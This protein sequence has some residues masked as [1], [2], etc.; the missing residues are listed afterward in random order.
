MRPVPNTIAL[1]GV[2][3]GNRNPSDEPIVA[4]STGSVGSIFDAFANASTT[5]TTMFADAV[6]LVVSE[7]IVASAVDVTMSPND[8]ST[9][10]SPVRPRPIASARPVWNARVP[11]AMPPP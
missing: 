7:R 10:S 5:G 8:E 11:S 4:A 6:L 2:D 1:H 9:P 3:T